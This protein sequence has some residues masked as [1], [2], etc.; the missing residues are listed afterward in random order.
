M[1]INSNFFLVEDGQHPISKLSCTKNTEKFG[2]GMPDTIVIHYTAGSSAA[3]SA[4]YLCRDEIKA[5]AHIVIGRNGEIYQ[6]VPFDTIAWHAGTSA[7]GGRTMLN[8]YSV[9]IELANAGV[10]IKTGNEYQAWFGTKYPASDVVYA[11]HRN[12]TKPRYW[13]AYTDKQ[14]EVCRDVCEALI[15]KFA[16]K[17]IV[18]HEEIAP[19]RKQDPGPA[20]PL[21][22]FRETLL[23]KNES[24]APNL[25][26][27]KGEVTA[28]LLNI[29]SGAGINYEKIAKPLEAGTKVKVLEEREGWFR[30]TTTIEGWVSKSHVTIKAK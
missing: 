25:L 5:S 7:Y 21:D 11:T 2:S 8:K 17:D 18:G 22:S 23:L 9:G 28:N 14:I 24:D 3:S 19:G 10:L 20:F 6:L 1:E 29:R 15:N 12:E 16:I 30:V 27:A 26:N 4:N 13:Q